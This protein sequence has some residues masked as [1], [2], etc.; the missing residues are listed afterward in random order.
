MHE[1][2]L[3]LEV[4]WEGGGDPASLTLLIT[5]KDVSRRFGI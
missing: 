2:M 4:E 1:R 5:E 3:P